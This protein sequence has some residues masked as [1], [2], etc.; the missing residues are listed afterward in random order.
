MPL[1]ESD[2]RSK[3]IDPKLYQR[4]WTEEHI[5]REETAGTILILNGKGKQRKGTTDYTLR[6]KVN[7]ESQPV[8]VAIIE[9]KKD[10]CAPDDGLEQ[11]K[12]YGAAKRF[13]VQFVYSTNG[14][15]F[16]EF[17]RIT[18]KTSEARPL[19]EF[20]TPDELRASYE[21]Q[22]GFSLESEAAK[23]LFFGFANALQVRLQ[24][25]AHC[26]LSG[27]AQ[28][29]EL[30]EVVQE[31]LS[32][33]GVQLLADEQP[34]DRQFS[35]RVL[36]RGTYV[37]DWYRVL[38]AQRVKDMRLHQIGEGKARPF[39][40]G[41]A[42][43]GFEGTRARAAGIL[44]SRN[45]GPERSWRYAEVARRLTDAVG[46]QIARITPIVELLRGHVS[47]PWV[48]RCTALKY[49][50]TLAR[51]QR[52]PGRP[53]LR[54]RRGGNSDQRGRRRERTSRTNERRNDAGEQAHP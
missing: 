44:A 14:H 19:D 32:G 13:N 28:V 20:P 29:D 40:I 47:L 17:N 43:E 41:Q 6:I 36:D 16:V 8:A 27:T 7:P 37:S 12:L 38:C 9:A 11:A 10:T 34:G 49:N 48:M 54:R 52:A 26:E 4:G 33:I 30:S 22:L 50:T 46:R 31:Q 18:Q 39:G 53:R 35:L 15:Q 5:K 42:D 2:T 23:P 45:P 1:S 51:R 25:L 24:Q 21:A 3:L